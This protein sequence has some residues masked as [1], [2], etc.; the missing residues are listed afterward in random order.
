MAGFAWTSGRPPRFSSAQVAAALKAEGGNVTRAA[1]RLKTG[2]TTLHRYLE[3]Y[4]HVGVVMEHARELAVR[5][6]ERA[7]QRELREVE[8]RYG[9]G[10]AR[11]ARGQTGVLVEVVYPDEPDVPAAPEVVRDGP[12][13]GRR[14][15]D[16]P[17][18]SPGWV[19]VEVRVPAAD[20]F[21]GQLQPGDRLRVPRL[22]AGSWALAG[23]AEVVNDAS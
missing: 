11:G 5:R 1:R 18:A 9:V 14:L 10:P 19:L 6:A 4:P 2:R 17:W 12:A 20:K 8:R 23:V 21:H 16:P 15:A 7:L 22:L 3:K 13:P